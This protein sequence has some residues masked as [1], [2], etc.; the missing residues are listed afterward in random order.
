MGCLGRRLLI[1]A[2]QRIQLALAWYHVRPH[3][4]HT[5]SG[6]RARDP[7]RPGTEVPWRTPAPSSLS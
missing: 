5:L 4:P 1:G 2:S 7:R 6:V 3:V